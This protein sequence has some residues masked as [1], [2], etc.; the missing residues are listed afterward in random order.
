MHNFFYL[1]NYTKEICRIKYRISV[2]SSKIIFSSNVNYKI[3]T[4]KIGEKNV[5]LKLKVNSE[6]HKNK[7]LLTEEILLKYILLQLQKEIT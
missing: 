3:F 2:D 1:L 7:I 5:Y 4:V 6:S